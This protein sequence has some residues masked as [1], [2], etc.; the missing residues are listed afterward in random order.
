MGSV[1]AFCF[2]SPINLQLD[3]LTVMVYEYTTERQPFATP[4]LPL[5]F[6]SLSAPICFHLSVIFHHDSVPLLE[7]TAFVNR[8]VP[9]SSQTTCAT[10]AGRN[11]ASCASTS[12]RR[13][14][15]SDTRRS[16]TR[17]AAPRSLTTSGRQSSR[18]R[19]SNLI[20]F[21]SPPFDPDL[22]VSPFS[23]LL[24]LGYLS[25]LRLSVTFFFFS[26]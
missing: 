19:R 13:R 23:P 20:T 1:A 10:A 6:L 8:T 22:F 11:G 4:A 12:T 5:G 9:P 24:F 2:S 21:L 18:A 26:F 14:T 3:P 15:S 17:R 25:P 16:C 7:L